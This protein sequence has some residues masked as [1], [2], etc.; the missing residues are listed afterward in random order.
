MEKTTTGYRN[1]GIG[2]GV[3][4]KN[5][6]GYNSIVIGVNAL[7]NATGHNN[8]GMGY[9]AVDD[10]T[11]GVENVSIGNYSSSKLTGTNYNVAVGYSAFEHVNSRY[12]TA[13]GYKAMEGASGS[14]GESNTAIGSKSIQSVTTGGYNTAIG[15]RTLESLT[16][17]SNNTAIGYEAGESTPAGAQNTICIGNGA[18]VTGDN[19]CR[20]GN[21]SIKVGIGTSSPDYKLSVS[22]GGI[23]LINS[24]SNYGTGARKSITNT[25][26][27]NEIHG[28]GG[29][30][31]GYDVGFLR[32]SAGGGTNTSEKSYIDL[33]GHD[34]NR[35]TFGTKGA[36]RMVIDNT[37]KVDIGETS[38]GAKLDI[39][40][41]GEAGRLFRRWTDLPWYFPCGSTGRRVTV[42]F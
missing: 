31:K 39:G 37:G 40:V 42:N 6:T 17:G 35:I 36:E 14:T 5:I 8:I 21:D 41:R 15:F 20:I 30:A 13:V 10:C 3:L 7:R 22:N 32:L 24:D 23:I 11:S 27:D 28:N 4:D 1:I 38:P 25:V 26:I 2:N 12:N 29:G 18:N 34:S 33:Y 16:T 19:M 9:S